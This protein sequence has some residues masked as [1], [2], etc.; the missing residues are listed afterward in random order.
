[1]EPTITLDPLGLEFVSKKEDQFKNSVC[2]FKVI[3]PDYKKKLAPL[4]GL[5]GLK[6]PFWKTETGGYM[7]TVKEKHVNNKVQLEKS[8]KYVAQITL[9]Y[10]GSTSLGTKGYYS[11]IDSA[12]DPD[13]TSVLDGLGDDSD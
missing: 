1:M 4:K 8:R 3:D 11:K 6:I 13:R 10:W 5:V 7:L 12:T 2:Y 9:E